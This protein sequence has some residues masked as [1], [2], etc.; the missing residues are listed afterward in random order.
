MTRDLEQPINNPNLAAAFI[1]MYMDEIMRE[2]DKT[3]KEQTILNLSG[4]ILKE[5]LDYGYNLENAFEEIV[6][7]KNTVREYLDNLKNE[8]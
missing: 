3:Q 6:K 8:D 2:Q 5:L 7:N 4:S 1:L